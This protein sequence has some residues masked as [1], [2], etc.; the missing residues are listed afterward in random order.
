MITNDFLKNLEK[1]APN[2]TF[3][4]RVEKQ[5]GPS[6]VL[7]I[8]GIMFLLALCESC[9]GGSSS[10]DAATVATSSPATARYYA[11]EADLPKCDATTARSLV[12]VKESLEF[13][14]C[15]GTTWTPIDLKG[16]KGDVGTKGEIGARGDTGVKGDSGA[17]GADGLKIV[18]MWRYHVD[19]LNAA[20]NIAFESGRT[21]YSARIATFHLVKF[22]DGSGFAS[23]SGV[24]LSTTGGSVYSENFSHAF[25]LK[26]SSLEQEY[27]A[28]FDSFLDERIRYKITLGDT[29]TLKVIVDVDGNFANNTDVSIPIAKVN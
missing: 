7:S 29:P 4:G 2:T 19:S 13:Q 12:Y 10:T 17:A 3:P 21:A 9:G 20:P 8:L 15:E 28:K 14:Y 22:S 24:L 26:S 6:I 16:A 18:D 11:T 23:S 5:G 25:F 1:Y 27:V